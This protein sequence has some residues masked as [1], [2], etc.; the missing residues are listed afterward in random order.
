MK[1]SNEGIPSNLVEFLKSAE[2]FEV[3][4]LD[5]KLNRNIFNFKS[6][7]IDFQPN[8]V[9][10]NVS[11]E[12]KEDLINAFLKDVERGGEAQRCW[13][14]QHGIRAIYKNQLVEIGIC[15]LC[16]WYRG[17]IFEEK[18]YGTFP[19]EEENQSKIIFDKIVA[20]IK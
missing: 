9:N 5:S 12:L 15:Y 14:P 16:G 17:Q 1:Y 4:F 13:I 2:N 7:Y 11:D 20:E 6:E 10:K 8:Q 18:F 19:N 3:W